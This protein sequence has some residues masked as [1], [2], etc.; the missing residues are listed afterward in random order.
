MRPI[1][2]LLFALLAMPLQAQVETVTT[3]TPPAAVEAGSTNSPVAAATNATTEILIASDEALM[4]T[5]TNYTVIYT[6]NVQATYGS[7]G[8]LLCGQLTIQ[9]EKESEEPHYI[10]AD[11]N[12]VLD[13]AR[14]DGKPI[15]ATA[16]RAT[17]TLRVDNG[18]TN[19]IVTLIGDVKGTTE[20]KHFAGET[21]IINLTTSTI[22]VPGRQQTGITITGDPVDRLPFTRNRTNAP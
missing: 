8:K 3:N 4:L 13:F 22:S 16:D 20:G 15:H 17:Y 2:S 9:A 6:G 12:V 14:K 18:Q 21:V 11:T 7:E 10:L 1:I 5:E 19:Q